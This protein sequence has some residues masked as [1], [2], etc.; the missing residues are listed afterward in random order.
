MSEISKL[1][2]WQTATH[3]ELDKGAPIVI[4]AVAPSDVHVVANQIIAAQLRVK[5]YKVI[6]LGA[7]T[8]LQ[9]VIE[10]WQS[11]SDVLAI[12]IGSV[13]GHAL[14]DLCDL[15]KLKQLYQ[16]TCPIIVGGN[17]SIG[18]E[19]DGSEGQ[20]LKDIG[21]DYILTDVTQFFDILD[22]LKNSKNRSERPSHGG[23]HE[24]DHAQSLAV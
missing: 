8:P 19:K 3:L 10:T 17:L 16:V 21:V 9:E 2:V 7:A 1:E 11:H 15:P 12:A 5:G 4:L 13:N 20:K 14:Q 24:F 6:N 18:A 22:Q 23:T